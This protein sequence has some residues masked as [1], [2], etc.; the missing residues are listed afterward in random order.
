MKKKLSYHAALGDEVLKYIC[1][2]PDFIYS[3]IFFRS[4]TFGCILMWQALC[5]FTCFI[6]L[7]SKYLRVCLISTELQ[8]IQK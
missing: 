7:F 5:P 3:L 2:Q 4:L 8:G 6:H 1:L